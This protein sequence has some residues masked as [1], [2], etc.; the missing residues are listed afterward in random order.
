MKVF[1]DV[2]LSTLLAVGCAGKGVKTTEEKPAG[3]VVMTILYDNY[4]GGPGLETGWGFSCLVQVDGMRVLFDTGGDWEVLSHN[5]DVLGVD[6]KSIDTVVLSHIHGDHTGGLRGFLGVNPEVTVWLPESFPGNFK[7][8]VRQAG[9]EVREVG[10]D[11]AKVAPNVF[12]TGEMGT[13][14]R[15]QSLVVRSAKGLVVVTGCAHP[16]VVNIA[17]RAK[18]TIGEDVYLVLGGFHLFGSSEGRI[19]SIIEDLRKLG[20][21]KVGPCHCSGDSA[22]KLFREAYGEDYV[23]V[24][25]GAVVR[26]EA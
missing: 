13:A 1:F 11:T 9:A 23:D 14:I 25:V 7:E 16:G 6:P 22:R 8:F 26:I 21:R 17:R 10:E 15:E 24:H 2:V 20:V 18:E 4:P 19:R 3:E 5:M 12:T